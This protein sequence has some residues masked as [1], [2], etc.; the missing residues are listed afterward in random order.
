MQSLFEKFIKGNCSSEEYEQVLQ[1]IQNNHNDLQLDNLMHD[2]WAQHLKIEQT[3][4]PDAK[5]LDVIHHQIAL[6]EKNPSRVIR[7]Y[8]GLLSAAAVLIVGLL[9]GSL[10]FIQSQKH[11]IL[12]QNITTPYGGKTQFTLPDGSSVWL[13]SGS[14]F[15]YPD[16]FND[17]RIVELTGEAYFEVEKQKQPFI[18]K[19]QFGEIEVLGTQFNVKAYENETFCTTLESGS[20]IFTN[21]YGKQAQ[22]E[23]GL[24][25]VFDESIFKMRSVETKLFTSWK[26]GQLIFRD[27]PLQ[28]MVTRLE[29]WYN[30][31][32]ELRDERIKNLKFTGTIEMETFSEVL[33]LIKV[34][35]PIKYTFDRKTRVLIISAP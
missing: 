24:Q 20:V 21:K 30:V 17:E 19:T 14:T 15:S 1:F 28:S 3:I 35:T 29:R 2:D 22:L 5:L 8:Q 4:K 33:E 13:N 6:K 9:I 26:D 11:E 10:F 27:E 25:V 31:K 16:R 18:V 12:T 34:T 32:I 23:P 7:I